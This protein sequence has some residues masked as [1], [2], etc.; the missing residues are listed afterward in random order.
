MCVFHA[1]EHGT[2][3]LR[4]FVCFFFLLTGLLREPTEVFSFHFKEFEAS[5]KARK[6]LK[7]YFKPHKTLK[8]SCNTYK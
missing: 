5:C 1:L 4:F 6:A 7:T 8:S 2:P 3:Q